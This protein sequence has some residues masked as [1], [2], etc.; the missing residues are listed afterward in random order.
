MTYTIILGTE[1]ESVIA[2]R[3][4]RRGMTIAVYIAHLADIAACKQTV[5]KVKKQRQRLIE[6]PSTLKLISKGM[7]PQLA[8]I[9]DDDFRAAEYHDDN[10]V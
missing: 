2:K 4:A 9:G 10:N 7:F 5:G 3:A 6:Q 1:T 8:G